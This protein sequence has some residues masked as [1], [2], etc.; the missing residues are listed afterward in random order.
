MINKIN[1]DAKRIV[2]GEPL[3]SGFCN[4]RIPSAFNPTATPIQVAQN[5]AINSPTAFWGSG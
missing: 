2:G 5:D 4:L 1:P 3:E